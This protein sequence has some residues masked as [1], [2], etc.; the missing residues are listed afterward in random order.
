MSSEAILF[1]GENWSG[2]AKQPMELY[3]L[4]ICFVPDAVNEYR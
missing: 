3:G 1:G 2:Y 4:G